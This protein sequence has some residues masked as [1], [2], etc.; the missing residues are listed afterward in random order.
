MKLLL[1]LSNLTALLI[2]VGCSSSPDP[3]VASGKDRVQ[4]RVATSDE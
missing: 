1:I 2:L 4:G 3:R